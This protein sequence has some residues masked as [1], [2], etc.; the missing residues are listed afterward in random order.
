MDQNNAPPP[1]VDQAAPP[2]APR[3]PKTIVQ[4]GETRVDDYFW[5][6]EK[7]NPEVRAHLEAENAWTAAQMRDTTE[8][9]ELL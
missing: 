4:H 7:D 8:L 3:R 6:R 5:L 2:L 9:Q 1:V